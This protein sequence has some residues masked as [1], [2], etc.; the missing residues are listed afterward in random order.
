[1]KRILINLRELFR[2]IDYIIMKRRDVLFLTMELNIPPVRKIQI[3][4]Y[5]SYVVKKYGKK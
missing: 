2:A 1:M 4:N 5:A 3:V